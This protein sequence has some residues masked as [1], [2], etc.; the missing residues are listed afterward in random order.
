MAPIGGTVLGLALSWVL[1]GAI[2]CSST[3]K[4]NV[5]ICMGESSWDTTLEPW[6][7]EIEYVNWG[8]MKLD[9]L[10]KLRLYRNL[11]FVYLRDNIIIDVNGQYCQ[12]LSLGFKIETII[13]MKNT[14]TAAMP[15]NR[16]YQILMDICHLGNLS[17]VKSVHNKALLNDN[18]MSTLLSKM[19][20][21]PN[22]K[23]RK[24]MSENLEQLSL[25]GD[26]LSYINPEI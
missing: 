6:D 20:I 16:P 17:F 19:N 4:S 7:T 24:D 1:S 11:D 21:I 9:L 3:N 23:H 14:A 2:Q 15:N 26:M 18:Q 8:R 12:Q 10:R 13:T 5:S 25:Q 22:L